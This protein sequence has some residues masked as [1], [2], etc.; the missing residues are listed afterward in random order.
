[1]FKGGMT[2]GEDISLLNSRSRLLSV[3]SALDVELGTELVSR[4]SFTE[5]L[6]MKI[7]CNMYNATLRSH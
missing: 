4:V 2:E 6:A 7:S 3:E 1:M 5:F